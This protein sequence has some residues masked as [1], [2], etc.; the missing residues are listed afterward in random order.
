M[1]KCAGTA[2][3]QILF[4]I[5]TTEKYW[6]KSKSY[7]GKTQGVAEGRG[8]W[9]SDH[10]QHSGADK[11][12]QIFPEFYSWAFVRNPFDRVVSSWLKRQKDGQ[13]DTD[14][15]FENWVDNGC[16]GPA[17]YNQMVD[18][19]CDS[20]GN[21]LCDFVGR[22]ENLNEDWKKVAD[23]LGFDDELPHLNQSYP[24]QYQDY[25]KSDETRRKVVDKFYDDFQVFQYDTQ[26]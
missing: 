24:H 3:R 20:S 9:N 16:A 5:S 15:S 26:K 8:Y 13:G 19:L 7:A 25:Y 18:I 14:G 2:M 6:I 23:H 1:P 12:V 11:A 4:P 21:I 22:Y 10:A 17:T